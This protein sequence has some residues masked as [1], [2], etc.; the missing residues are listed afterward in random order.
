MVEKSQIKKCLKKNVCHLEKKIFFI[1]GWSNPLPPKKTN[2][3]WQNNLPS[4]FSLSSLYLSVLLLGQP[5][6]S[7]K[8]FF[9][10]IQAKA[11]PSG[12][13]SW[14]NQQKGGKE[15]MLSYRPLSLFSGSILSLSLTDD[16]VQPLSF[17]RRELAWQ[18]LD[19]PSWSHIM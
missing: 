8:I 16:A 1:Q 10:F 15:R 3:D 13:N 5:A 18:L 2:V 17:F 6:W 9:H 7:A 19:F 14:T 4:F 11:Y 12:H